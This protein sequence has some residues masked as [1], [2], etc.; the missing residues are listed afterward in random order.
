MT[1]HAGSIQRLFYFLLLTRSHMRHKSLKV[2]EW[3]FEVK[4]CLLSI[5]LLNPTGNF[6]Y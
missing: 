4:P 2:H 3:R 1:E 5:F 6:D